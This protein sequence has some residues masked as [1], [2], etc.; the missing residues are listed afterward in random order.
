MQKPICQ[1]TT[2]QINKEKLKYN[3]LKIVLK[4]STQ[5]HSISAPLLLSILFIQQ[6]FWQHFALTNI[7]ETNTVLLLH[8]V[9]LVIV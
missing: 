3:Y 2:N 6:L 9:Y 7:L 4:Y 8:L 5:L 1:I